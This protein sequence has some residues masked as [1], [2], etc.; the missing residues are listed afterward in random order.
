[1]ADV[2]RRPADSCTAPGAR[3]VRIAVLLLLVVFCLGLILYFRIVL[4]TAIVSTHLAYLPIALGGLWFGRR[5]VWVAAFMGLAVVSSGLLAITPESPW[6]DLLRAF[7][8]VVLAACVG[9]VSDRAAKAREAEE[10]SRRDLE[11]A[12]Q[13]LKASER[14]AS[15]GQLSAGVA[16]ELNNPL[17]SVLL[18]THMLLKQTPAGDPRRPDLEMVAAEATRC[19]NIVRS[20][21]D[22]ARQSSVTRVPTDLAEMARDVLGILALNARASGSTLAADCEDGLPSVMLDPNQMRQVLINLVQ[23]GLDAA[24]QGGTVT[25]RVRRGTDRG[26]IEILVQ[27]NGCG[28]PAENMDKLFTPFFTTKQCRGGTGLGLALVYGIVTMHSGEVSASSEP[29][30]GT[31]FRILLPIGDAALAPGPRSGRAAEPEGGEPQS[32]GR[33]R[34]SG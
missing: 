27:D 10:A 11:R 20:L 21:L 32:S 13:R 31:V 23:N 5:A 2:V 17:G 6:P 12:Q 3:R 9:I 28:I 33:A 24:G 25:L 4:G 8:F 18:Y 7:C 14:L 26:R 15:M 30:R 29:G 1:M 16:H 34:Q 19:G 22:F